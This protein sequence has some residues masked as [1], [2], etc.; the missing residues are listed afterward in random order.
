MLGVGAIAYVF[1]TSPQSVPAMYETGLGQTPLKVSLEWPVFALY[2]AIAGL[3]V[4]RRKQVTHCDA[5][6]LLLSL[7]L[8]AASELF[9][10][11][12][13]EVNSSTNLLGHLYKVFAYYF[14]YLAIY[15]DAVRRPFRRCG[16]CSPTTT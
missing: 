4:L 12:Y 16:T 7:L 2:L 14:L 13:V 10:I 8:M 1:L 15:A 5:N 11:V 3:L 6:S 9:F